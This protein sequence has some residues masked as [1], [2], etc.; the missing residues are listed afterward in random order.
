TSESRI[1]CLN[2]SIGRSLFVPLTLIRMSASLAGFLVGNAAPTSG[3]I[4]NRALTVIGEQQFKNLEF[5]NP[6]GCHEHPY[7]PLAYLHA[8]FSVV[9]IRFRRPRGCA[10]LQL[11]TTRSF[12]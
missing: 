10:R 4:S 7:W 3:F 11:Q 6:E 8:D 2:V 9:I 12:A 5:S 1:G